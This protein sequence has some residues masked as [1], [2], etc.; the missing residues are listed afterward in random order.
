MRRFAAISGKIRRFVE[1]LLALRSRFGGRASAGVAFATD[2]VAAPAA[3]VSA[4]GDVAIERR[5]ESA[6]FAVARA[7]ASPAIVGQVE[8]SLAAAVAPR[9][10]ALPHRHRELAE[11]S[12]SRP[13]A[14]ATVARQNTRITSAGDRR[15]TSNGDVR[16][17]VQH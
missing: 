7:S 2:R 1:R 3:V 11:A 14:A 5:A 13:S 8:A 9:A 4:P 10:A 17:V 6:P 12:R 15:V 16:I